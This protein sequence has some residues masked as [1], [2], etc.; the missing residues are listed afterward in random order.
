[1][2]R[3]DESRKKD[4]LGSGAFS[5]LAVAAAPELLLLPFRIAWW[6]LQGAARIVRAVM[7]SS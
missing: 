4:R 7:S 3:S 5:E 2:A 6:L 1:M